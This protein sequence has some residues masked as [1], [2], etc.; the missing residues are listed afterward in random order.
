[1]LTLPLDTELSE[2]DKR[3]LEEQCDRAN[4]V[5]SENGVQI[6]LHSPLRRAVA[7]ATGLFG[8]ADIPIKECAEIYE[9]SLSEYAG[10]KSL[11][12]RVDNF[13]LRTLKKYKENR[14]LLVGHSKFFR[15]LIPDFV[16]KKQLVGN[17]SIWRAQLTVEGEWKPGSLE[18]LVPGW[19]EGLPPSERLSGN[20]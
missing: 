6:I 13:R 16:E 10:L 14:I 9:K 8:K 2:D 5:L 19:R 1:L 4:Q 3:M 17:V 7:T 18:L 11:K 12:T 15:S 20:G